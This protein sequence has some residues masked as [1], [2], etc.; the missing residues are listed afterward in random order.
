MPAMHNHFRRPLRLAGRSLLALLFLLTAYALTALALGL[1]PANRGFTQVKDG[2]S[3]YVLSNGVHADLVLPVV[4]LGLRW[5]EWI[6]PSLFPVD[7]RHSPYIAFGWG[8]QAF[9]LETPTWA[10][11][12]V[13]TAIRATLLPSPSALHVTYHRQAPREN[14]RCR[15]ILISEAQY[16][17]LAA[18]ILRAFVPDENGDPQLILAP[19][20]FDDDRFFV[21]RGNYDYINTCNE[22]VN[23]ALRRAGIRACLWAPFDRAIFQQ[24]EKIPSSS[25]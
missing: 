6:E 20:Y 3:I 25:L 17:T 8:D 11:L 24:L 23:R 5:D 7:V 12:K 18:Y 22:W 16:L 14:E 13:S 1:A 15:R 4:A 21:A 2:I 10:D 9:Y 19:G